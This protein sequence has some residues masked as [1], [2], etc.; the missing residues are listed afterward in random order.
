MEGIGG[1]AGW[2][3]IFILEGIATVMIAVVS[4]VFMPA[5]IGSAKFFTEEERSFARKYLILRVEFYLTDPLPVARFR[6]AD[7]VGTS[8]PLSEPSEKFN[9]DEEKNADVRTEVKQAQPSTVFLENEK[10]EWRE[11]I[12]GM[13]YVRRDRAIIDGV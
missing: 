13:R 4:S 6:A 9:M 3:W 8:A 5:D 1:L 12:R 7:M 11:V 10:F 2:K